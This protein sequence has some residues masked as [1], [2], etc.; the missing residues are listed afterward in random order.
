MSTIQ[1]RISENTH[2]AIREISRQIGESM[3]SVVERAV[4]RYRR[5]LFLNSLN[6]DFDE[7]RNDEAA[8]RDEL[9]ERGIWE[10]T[11]ADGESRIA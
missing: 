1:V 5:E 11:I 7:L 6:R 2:T 9:D 8:W 10:V 4:E 3:Q